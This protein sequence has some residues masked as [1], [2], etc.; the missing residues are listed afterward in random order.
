MPLAVLA[1]FA[2]LPVAVWQGAPMWHPG[3]G[4]NWVVTAAI[5]LI[6]IPAA[7]LVGGR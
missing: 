7:T 4:I 2:A 3:Y 5:V 1:T 6:G